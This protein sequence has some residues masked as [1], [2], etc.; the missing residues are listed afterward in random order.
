MRKFLP[1]LIILFFLIT[2]PALAARKADRDTETDNDKDGIVNTSQIASP[3]CDPN[4]NWKNHGENVSAAAKS[5]IGK[6]E[7]GENSSPSPTASANP[8]VNPSSSSSA[9]PSASA[10]AT[11][12]ASPF[13]QLEGAKIEISA[14]ITFLQN[15]IDSLKHLI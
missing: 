12:S 1:V 9:S 15:V 5:D 3:T 6:K 7:E 14:L 4:A 13:T 8:S 2:T 10:S 11:P